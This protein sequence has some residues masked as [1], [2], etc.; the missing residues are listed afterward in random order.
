[1]M[2]GYS[3]SFTSTLMDVDDQSRKPYLKGMNK[4]HRTLINEYYKW[5][6]NFFPT[7]NGMCR[8]Y[9]HSDVCKSR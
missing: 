5:K 1:M 2:K 7:D 8:I 9:I 6:Q 3:I 4:F